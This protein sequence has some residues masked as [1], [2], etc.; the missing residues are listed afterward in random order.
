MALISPPAPPPA[1]AQPAPRERRHSFRRRLAA[2]RAPHKRATQ[3]PQPAARS[4]GSSVCPFSPACSPDHRIR[5]PVHLPVRSA[6]H[7]RPC[8]SLIVCTPRPIAPT[9]RDTT[10]SP[11]SHCHT[12]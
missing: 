1:R 4:V 2:V 12:A 11:H 3:T 9:L 6:P 8:H 7:T 10:R 5:P